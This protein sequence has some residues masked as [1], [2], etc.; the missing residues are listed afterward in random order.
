MSFLLPSQIQVKEMPSTYNVPSHTGLRDPWAGEGVA[1][2]AQPGQGSFMLN[3]RRGG[4]THSNIKQN[5]T[6]QEGLHGP[7]PVPS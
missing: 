6:G 4:Y 1:V 5:R 2:R 3:R 7:F